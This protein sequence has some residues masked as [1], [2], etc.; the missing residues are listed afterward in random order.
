M[1]RPRSRP[2]RGG[3]VALAVAAGTLTAGGAQLPRHDAVA[4]TAARWR[5]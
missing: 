4:A 2:R 3:A 1:G 5:S